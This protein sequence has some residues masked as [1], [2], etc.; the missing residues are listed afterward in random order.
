MKGPGIEETS[1]A[2][3]ALFAS[4]GGKMVYE[5]R[6]TVTFTGMMIHGLPM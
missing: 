4:R 3:S 6:R 2:Q 5:T 1:T